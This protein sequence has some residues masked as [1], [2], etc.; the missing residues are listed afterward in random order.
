[1]AQAA[2]R[3]F[4]CDPSSTYYLLPLELLDPIY[5]NLSSFRDKLAF[6]LANYDRHFFL[7]FLQ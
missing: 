1:M 3:T 6:A 5:A 7:L 2:T 4:L